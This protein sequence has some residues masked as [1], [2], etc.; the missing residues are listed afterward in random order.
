M[1]DVLLA[2][3]TLTF[4]ACLFAPGTVFYTN[5]PEFPFFFG[6]A[7]L[8]L[9]PLALFL[10]T[11]TLV[12]FMFRSDRGRARYLAGIVALSALLWIQGNLLVWDYGV[13]NGEPIDWDP[14][15]VK[16]LAELALWIPV[17]VM[18]RQ[19][20]DL[21]LKRLRTACLFL[22]AVQ[23]ISLGIFA[24]RAPQA[25]FK[26]WEIDT[27]QKFAFSS[28]QNVVILVLDSFQSTLFQELLDENPEYRERFQ[29]F[30][31]FRN[32]TSGY[33]TTVLSPTLIMTGHY[34]QNNM[35]VSEFINRSFVSK[36]SIVKALKERG[37]AIHMYPEQIRWVTNDPEVVS[38]I[39]PYKGG[40]SKETLARIGYL[41]EIASFRYS[42]HFIKQWTAT[43]C[44]TRLAGLHLP[45]IGLHSKNDIRFL[46]DLTKKFSAGAGTRVFKYY[47]LWGTHPPHHLTRDLKIKR[48][49]P[50]GYASLKETARGCVELTDRVLQRFVKAGIYDNTVFFVIADHGLGEG[51]RAPQD[52]R[53]AGP[54]SSDVHPYILKKMGL[55]LPLFM[56]KPLGAK[57]A[58]QIS[59]KP[60]SLADIPATIAQQLDVPGEYPGGSIFVQNAGL[61]KHA[62]K[63]LYY[64]QR[65][66]ILDMDRMPNLEEILIA[67]HAWLPGSWHT[68]GTLL[69]NGVPVSDDASGKAR[70][71][72]HPLPPNSR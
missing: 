55:A 52:L 53:Q 41:M 23:S 69:Q 10:F 13:L 1:I 33:P 38:N 3:A 61:D 62:R 7:L 30:T 42:P 49:N 28:S 50:P 20:P 22:I 51:F 16:G 6:E 8:Y 66:K 63:Y 70:D 25:A 58:L 14:H 68:G 12:P 64:K 45:R 21:F 48:F 18:A 34:Y 2:S 47:H 72:N 67:G 4:T 59:D 15:F 36:S 57:G 54:Q 24:A 27:S 46:N 26:R 39:V 35:S 31:Y 17:L 40:F 32:A 43:I 37:F 44:Y 11:A 5:V 29:G 19:K 71:V 56:V 60:V 65:R 9:A